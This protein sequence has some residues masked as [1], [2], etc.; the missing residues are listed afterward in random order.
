MCKKR[1]NLGLISNY[2]T[3]HPWFTR[4]CFHPFFN[5]FLFSFFSL[6]MT[7]LNIFVLRKSEI[8]SPLKIILIY[9]VNNCFYHEGISFIWNYCFFFIITFRNVFSWIMYYLFL[10]KRLL[11]N[12]LYS[13]PLLILKFFARKRRYL[14]S[15]CGEKV[16]DIFLILY[17]NLHWREIKIGGGNKDH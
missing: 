11:F 5:L 10:L 7:K 6:A 9:E 4:S 2:V 14:L 13:T 8:C 1:Y 16:C 17:W 3:N 15:F 12:Y